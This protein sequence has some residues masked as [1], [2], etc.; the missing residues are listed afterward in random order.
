MIIAHDNHRLSIDYSTS[1]VPIKHLNPF[2][3]RWCASRDSTN[4]NATLSYGELI[5][6][7][8]LLL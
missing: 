4:Q 8:K 1:S 5:S 7:T 2:Y 6:H 3:S